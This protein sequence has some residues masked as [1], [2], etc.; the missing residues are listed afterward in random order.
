MP[1]PNTSPFKDDSVRV[2]AGS[3]CYVETAISAGQEWDT[4]K[5]ELRIDNRGLG[6]RTNKYRNMHEGSIPNRITCKKIP[7]QLGAGNI[8]T[9]RNHPLWALLCSH[10]KED[11]HI[12]TA[13]KSITSG[14][15]RY[16][17]VDPPEKGEENTSDRF[18]SSLDLIEVIAPHNN[19]DALIILSAW[20]K[21]A[22][23][24]N[25]HKTH[26]QCAQHTYDIFP[27]VVCSRPH[28]F[29]R[30]PLLLEK[31]IETVWKPNNTN[32]SKPWFKVELNTL[33]CNIKKQEKI[34]RR[35]QIGLPPEKV[36]NRINKYHPY[37]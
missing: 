9:W 29:I 34:A 32:N 35:Q 24:I 23:K 17:W 5:L 25:I 14:I 13:L 3:A 37:F 31:Y 6:D 21:E 4:N 7:D 28:L 33:I 18:D 27:K 20:A 16:I 26:Y 8:T 22:R 15:R 36:M 12:D 2:I 1:Y 10:I 30:W 19:L 11:K